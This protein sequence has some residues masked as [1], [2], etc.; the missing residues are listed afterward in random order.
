MPTWSLSVVLQ[1]INGYTGHTVYQTEEQE[2]FIACC[3]LSEDL[4]TVAFGEENGTVKVWNWQSDECIVLKGHKEAVKNFYLLKSSRLLSWSFDGT[5]K[6]WNIVTGELERDLSCHEDAILSCAVS[7]D[8]TMF[9][10][11][12]A[13]KTAKIWSFETSSVLHKLNGHKGC[14][15]CCAFSFNNELLTTGDDNGDIRV[16]DISKGE[17]LHLYSRYSVDEGESAHGGWVTD[18]RFSPDNKILVSSGGYIKWWNVDT[19]Q[20]LQTFYTNGTNLK[21]LHVSPDFKVCVTV[22][23]LG[24]LYVLQIM[25]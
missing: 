3:C 25:K 18:L 7:P 14:V 21:S 19:G 16:W 8:T 13:D 5:V 10:T 15:R 22:D 6:F 20:P 17:L 9:A 12:S 2:H 24:I 1:L 23:N 4:Q 11:T